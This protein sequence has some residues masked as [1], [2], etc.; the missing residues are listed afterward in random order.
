MPIYNNDSGCNSPLKS[1]A[2]QPIAACTSSCPQTVFQP[3]QGWPI[4]S[5]W[6]PPVDVGFLDQN[7]TTL[8]QLLK[9]ATMLNVRPERKSSGRDFNPCVSSLRSKARGRTSCFNQRSRSFVC[10]SRNT[11]VLN[12]PFFEELKL[13]PIILSLVRNKRNQIQLH[14]ETFNKQRSRSFVGCSS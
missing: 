12:F 7:Y 14:K 11:L 8:Q 1:M 9:F 4:I 6:S 5:S 13:S 10:S 2:Y 3:V